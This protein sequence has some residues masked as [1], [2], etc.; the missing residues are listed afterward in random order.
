MGA[1]FSKISFVAIL[2]FTYSWILTLF[3]FQA[4]SPDSLRFIHFWQNSFEGFI[5]TDG[6][7]LTKIQLFAAH[8]YDALLASSHY[9]LGRGRILLYSWYGLE[10][11]LFY[12][13][14]S[15]PQNFLISVTIFLNS[16]AIAS[17][18]TKNVEKRH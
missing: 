18:A 1:T 3:E 13:F 7:L 14:Q 9:D 5:A 8:S 17:L 16:H 15:L 11:F 4:Y 12:L 10:T 2:L 6:N